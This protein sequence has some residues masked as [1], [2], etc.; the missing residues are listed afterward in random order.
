MQELLLWLTGQ[1]YATESI[2]RILAA[3]PAEY[4]PLV[5]DKN[6]IGSVNPALRVRL[7][8]PGM[9]TLAEP[10]TPRELE[11]LILLREPLSIKDIA[12]RLNI[13]YATVKRHTINIYSKLGVNHRWGAV[14]KAE[15]LNMLPAR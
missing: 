14:S 3:F 5:D 13:S 9:D 10:L 6:L 11:V 8:S 2:G 4:S 12:L 15:D 1:G 7:P